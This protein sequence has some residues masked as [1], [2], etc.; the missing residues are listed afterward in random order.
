MSQITIMQKKR[1]DGYSVTNINDPIQNIVNKDRQYNV[2]EGFALVGVVLSLISVMLAAGRYRTEFAIVNATGIVFM[3]L[4]TLFVASPIEQIKNIRHNLALNRL[5]TLAMCVSVI[6][7]FASIIFIWRMVF[8]M[9]IFSW[10]IVFTAPMSNDSITIIALAYTISF[11]T[12]MG[13]YFLYLYLLWQQF[14]VVM[15][16]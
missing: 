11:M 12:Q 2:M 13:A 10:Q 8:A 7:Y 4:A 5:I 9:K 3:I 15:Q 6:I 16:T 14:F 1:Y